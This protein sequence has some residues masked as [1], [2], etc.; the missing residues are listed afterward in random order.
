MCRR[1]RDAREHSGL[2]QVA[3]A[4]ALGKPQNFVSKCETGQRRID[5][6]E[7]ADFAA[8]YGTTLEALVPAVERGGRSRRVAEPTV[9]PKKKQKRRGKG[10]RRPP[11]QPE[12]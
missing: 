11:E 3:A 8:L 1:L 5:P 2:K 9:Q 7:L 6:I 12:S 10:K 4:A